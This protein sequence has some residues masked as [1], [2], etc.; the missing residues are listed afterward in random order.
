MVLCQRVKEF[1]ITTMCPAFPGVTRVFKELENAGV[2]TH[3][4]ME[5]NKVIVPQTDVL[6][7]GAW[8]PLYD[9]L[10]EAFKSKDVILGVLWT[11]TVTQTDMSVVEVN[12]INHVYDLL[13]QGKIDFIWFGSK[14]WTK[15]YDDDRVYHM[16]YPI[17]PVDLIKREKIGN[18]KVKNVSLF[19][20]SHPRKNIMNQ[21]SAL[22]MVNNYYN[23]KL[24]TNT[25]TPEYIDFSNKI[26]LTYNSVAWMP[27]EEY[28]RLVASMDAGLQVSHNGVESFNYVVI[29]HLQQNVPVVMSK[30][31]Y[32]NYLDIVGEA[33]IE[34][35]MCV[36]DPTD[37][38]E[39]AET[40]CRVLE[41]PRFRTM[42]R[43]YVDKMGVVSYERLV[44]ILRRIVK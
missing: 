8:T 44:N 30:S 18:D 24:H 42:G 33:W 10:I 39:I 2:S 9:H 38:M 13:K 14:E 23:T 40:V 21:L 28:R 37:I 43:D 5:G 7:L 4:P 19:C 34:K 32:K 25:M 36:D 11:S 41:N 22:K 15:V 35:Y 1:K 31:I 3:I 20:P 27:A 6:I 26:G 29:D 12:Y 16:P 17:T